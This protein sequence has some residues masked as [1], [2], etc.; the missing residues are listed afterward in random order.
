MILTRVFTPDAMGEFFFAIAL[1]SLVLLFTT[2]GTHFHLVRAVARDPDRGLDRLGEVIKLRVPLTGLALLVLSGG[3]LMLAPA[4]APIV[5]L[6]SVFVLVGDFA[7]TFGAYLV[8]RREF[9]LR[10][11]VALPG[12]IA[13]L[14][15]V[16][17]VVLAGATLEHTLL[18]FIGAS[19]VAVLVGGAVVHARYGWLSLPRD[20][21]S[22]RWLMGVCWPFLVLEA[23][24]LVQF[25]IDTLMV[26]W[27]LSSEAAAQYETAYRLLE[28][29]RL[30]IG[31]LATIAFPVCALLI[32][33]RD[34]AGARAYGTKVVVIA[35]AI[36]LGVMLLGLIGPEWI[37]VTVWGSAYAGTG[38]IL[39]ILFLS[40]PLVFVN[41]VGVMVANAMGQERRLMWL[42]AFATM[43]NITMNALAIPQWGPEGAAW[44]TLITEVVILVGLV[45]TVRRAA[46]AVLAPVTTHG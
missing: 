6:T 13:L 9:K 32:A 33:R 1:A 12:P 26:F 30:A 27:I 21:G 36:G 14:A 16:P 19:A 44:T 3:A 42:M 39:R 25:K 17:L 18:C 8:G 34:W 23:L 7:N 22:V 24:Q 41:L 40:A 2:F 45:A 10:F 29:S 35:A 38:G 43:C 20:L 11:L 46:E 5:A 31:P 15:A 28:V 37:M 4:V